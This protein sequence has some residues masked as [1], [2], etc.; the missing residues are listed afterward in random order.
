MTKEREDLELLIEYLRGQLDEETRARME[1]RIADD[2]VLEEMVRFLSDIRHETE[3]A[4]WKKMQ[5]P[6]HALFE[7]LL[8]DVNHNQRNTSEE[9]GI[10]IYDSRLL[11]LPEGVRS[12]A[13]D[14][15][16]VKYLIGNAELEVSVYPVSPRSFEVIGLL[17]G[18]EP[19][20]AIE[21]ILS[22]GKTKFTVRANRFNLFRYPRIP[23]G[24]YT[25]SLRD[26]GKSIGRISIDL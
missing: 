3:A 19:G 23:T 24:S 8:K 21:V 17:S 15:R 9:Y 5:R 22:A 18:I 14:T 10:T 20:E 6:S 16:R 4:D 12:G 7:R 1:Q 26:G 13:V 25:M 2:P 11:P